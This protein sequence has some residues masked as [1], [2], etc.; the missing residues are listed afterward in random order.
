MQ[1]KCSGLVG[2]IG[3]VSHNSQTG[4]VSPH[5]LIEL[6]SR[7]GYNELI[8]LNGLVGHSKLIKLTGLVY[9]SNGLNGVIDLVNLNNIAGHIGLNSFYGHAILNGLNGMIGHCII[10][11]INNDLVGQISFFGVIGCIRHNVLVGWLTLADC[12]II[13]CNNT[14]GI[15]FSPHNIVDLFGP[16]VCSGLVGQISRAG[17]NGLIGQISLLGFNSLISLHSP[18]DLLASNHWLIGSNGLVGFLG[19]GPNSFVDRNDFVNY[20]GLV[21]LNDFVDFIGHNGLISFTRFGINGIVCLV[22]LSLDGFIDLI[23][24]IGLGNI[25][26]YNLGIFSLISLSNHWLPDRLAALATK[27]SQQLKH[28][29]SLR[30]FQVLPKF[31][32][33]TQPQFI[34]LPCCFIFVCL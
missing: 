5:E 28:A 22:S 32:T 31:P 33:W 29:A 27:I 6:N 23:S 11:L 34:L 19:L 4:L 15:C 20:I 8:Y 26:L 17:L 12:W 7:A 30:L 9:H 25:S 10:G 13:G 3:S 16:I 2:Q 24:L 14:A 18:I 1:L 21:S